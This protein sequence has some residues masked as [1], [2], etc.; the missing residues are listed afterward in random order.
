MDASCPTEI[1]DE[2][3]EV[4][5]RAM[6]ELGCYLG[7]HGYADYEPEELEALNE[8]YDRAWSWLMRS[9]RAGAGRV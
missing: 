6:D 5:E 9:R 4:L 2:V 8:R 1:P 7:D 3:F